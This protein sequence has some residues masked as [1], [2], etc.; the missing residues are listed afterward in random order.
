M[1]CVMAKRKNLEMTMSMHALVLNHYNG[2]LESTTL[3]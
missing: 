2:P 3:A 1:S